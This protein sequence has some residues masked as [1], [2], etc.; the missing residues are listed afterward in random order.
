MADPTD[1]SKEG[2]ELATKA[3]TTSTQPHELH[4]HILENVRHDSSGS[5]IIAM[6]AFACAAWLFFLEFCK[7]RTV[8]KF[9]FWGFVFEA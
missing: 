9:S 1:E 6:A 7:G 3:E 4:F 8:C 2:K 5:A